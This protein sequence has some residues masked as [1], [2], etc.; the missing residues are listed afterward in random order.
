[1]AGRKMGWCWCRCRR[2]KR[3]YY[4][5]KGEGPPLIFVH[6]WS[7]NLN[8]WNEQVD[9]FSKKYRT[10]SYDWR[11]M[12]KSSGAEPA[13]TMKEL[14]DELAGLIKAFAIEKPIICGHSEGGAIAMRYAVDYPNSVKALVLA[15][16]AL[17]TKSLSRQEKTMYA[18]TKLS[19]K[20]NSL[21]GRD[22]L[23][24]MIPQLK[25]SF[26][27]QQ[28][29]DNNPEFIA[30]WEK[31]FASNTVPGIMNGMRAWDW[32]QDVGQGL[33]KVKA[34]T[35]LL[36]GMEDALIKLP[37]MQTIQLNLGEVSQLTTLK[38]SGHMS[39]VEVPD[40]FNKQMDS[41]LNSLQP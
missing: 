14:G 41:F 31:Q 3:I 28:F 5:V 20:I 2:G 21:K 29:I 22:P 1:M 34:P 9:F 27:A 15:D 7:L 33:G 35:L 16:T 40:Q 38:G 25:T 37:Y 32:R 39:P 10:Y 4:R 8:Y 26:Y 18:I 30:A 6:G 36:W 23:V 11:G 19:I 12:G 17:N 13:Y 24:A